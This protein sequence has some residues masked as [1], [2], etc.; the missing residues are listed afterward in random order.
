MTKAHKHIFAT[1]ELKTISLALWD[2]SASLLARPSHSEKAAYL[3]EMCARVRPWRTLSHS[4]SALVLQSLERFAQIPPRRAGAPDYR[5]QSARLLEV[6]KEL[7]DKHYQLANGED[8]R[9]R[10]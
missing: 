7:H 8:F 9:R 4:E 3:A 5:V 2:L 10:R 6:V 1:G